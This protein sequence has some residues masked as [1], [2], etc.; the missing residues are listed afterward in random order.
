MSTQITRDGIEVRIEDDVE[1]WNRCVERSPHA[2]PFH[3]RAALDVLAD[4]AGATL[5]PLVG[6]KGQEPVGVLPLF[7]L[8]K[9]PLS[10]VFSPP[11]DLWV[12]YLGPA[13]CNFRKLKRRKAERRHRRF[14]EGC[15]DLVE[16]ECRPRFSLVRTVTR[17]PDVRPFE[18]NDFEISPRHTYVVDLSKDAETLLSEFSSDAR[19]NVRTARD[20]DCVV[21]EG[22]PADIERT[23]EQVQARHDAQGETY[24]LEPS[25]VLDLHERLPEGYVRPYACRVDGEFAAG[26][27][28]MDAGDTVYRWQ[29]GAKPDVDLPVNDYL[30]WTIIQEASER[31]RTRYDLVGA[32]KPRLCSYKAKFN[33]ELATYYEVQRGSRSMNVVSEVYK[34]IR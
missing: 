8:S 10:T 31:G 7:E 5:Y 28:V 19:S 17:Y 25:V 11:P 32:N 15:L 18:W 3:H 13:L 22:G 24:L 21:E 29:G 9:G 16:A 34:R 27:V 1:Q 30:D 20:A 4:H 12:P 2:T 23:I 14:V 6:Y 26:M 33:P